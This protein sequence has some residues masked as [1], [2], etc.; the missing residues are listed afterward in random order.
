VKTPLL[1]VD[2]LTVGYESAGGEVHA[3]SE[4]SFSVE[5]GERVG[6]VGES[7]SGK[8]TL[9]L[10]LMRLLPLGAQQIAGRI[11][12][13]GVDLSLLPAERIRLLR[14]GTAAMVFQDPLRAFDPLRTIG[15]QMSDSYRAHH[16]RPT[17]Q[18]RTTRAVDVLRSVGMPSPRAQLSR[19][20]HELSGG[21]LQ[22]SLIALGLQNAPQLLIADEPT[23]ALDVTIQSQIIRLL[24]ELDELDRDRSADPMALV[25]VSHNL[26][27]VR[28]L[29]TRIIVMYAGRIVEDAPAEAFFE[30][31]RHPYGAALLAA[32][33]RIAGP[34]NE[35]RPIPGDPA[36][37]TALPSGCSF[38]PRCAFKLEVCETRE[39]PYEAVPG[40]SPNRRCAC[41]VGNA[42][43]L[44]HAPSP[45]I[46]ITK[47]EPPA[48]PA[49]SPPIAMSLRHVTKTYS[50]ASPGF[51]RR[52]SFNA[53]VDITLD[54][55]SGETLALVGESGSG[56]STLAKLILGLH[57]PTTGEVNVFGEDPAQRK[58]GIRRQQLIQA[59]F[60]DPHGSLNPRMTVE[61]IISEPLRNQKVGRFERTS[62]VRDVLDEVRLPPHFAAR[63]PHEVSGGQA[64]RIAIARALIGNP[65]VVILDEPTASL[66]VSIQ[67]R[68]IELLREVQA[69]HG[70]TYVF[71]S[72]DLAA[73]REI[74]S[75]VAVMYLGRIVEVRP[76]DAFFD[77]QLH[78]YSV[79]LLSA[80]PRV[81][82]APT[83]NSTIVLGGEPP[84][85][86]AD[87]GGCPFHPR[88]PIAKERC[89][90]EEP[91][92][93]E[94]AVGGAV[95]CHF[96]GQFE[97]PIMAS[98][99][100]RE[101]T[102]V[103]DFDFRSG[104]G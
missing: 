68:V 97:A 44:G 39:P 86:L 11:A 56:K 88:C 15:S 62:R 85:A 89:S 36:D 70:L 13:N 22:R 28:Q 75:R 95:A 29:C 57:R 45:V 31:P 32:L 47:R 102:R 83:E 81:D 53:V 66:D 80:V 4:V 12:L 50:A 78:P 100:G 43:P 91:L 35:V 40:A 21:M 5:P 49:S 60:Q 23:T 26:G 76:A 104:R 63:Y 55:A 61:Q 14:G 6:I 27:L 98:P 38:A 82:V 103:S 58:S 93:S 74:A 1:E 54:V 72:H 64:Q 87:P 96:P 71:V 92:L 25:L 37:I 9:A 33:P 94:F 90:V 18:A 41:F 79:A 67:S 84:S 30:A 42:R 69:R 7:G 52:K 77:A 2:G 20:P 19:R 3:V 16:R 101:G 59:V 48:T 17:R 8:T 51:S 65:K 99:A 34:R 24:S 73:V 46:Q 10:A